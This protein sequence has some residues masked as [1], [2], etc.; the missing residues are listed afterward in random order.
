MAWADATAY[1][2]AVQNPRLAFRDA[3]LHQGELAT[4]RLGLP[5]IYTGSFAAVFQMRR[6]AGPPHLAL[7]CFT[8]Q[9]HGLRHRYQQIDAHLNGRRLP[10]MVRFA[11][12]DEGILVGQQRYPLLKMDWVEGL[13]LDQFL[14]QRLGQAGEKRVLRELS[15]LW[16]RLGELLRE[17]EIGHGDLQHG[18]VMLVPVPGTENLALKLIDYDGMYVPE[19]ADDPP[20]EIGHP[21]YQHPGRTKE[22]GY[23]PE[24]DRFSHLV[25]Y[26]TLQAL[27]AGGRDLWQQFYNGD[28]LLLGPDDFQD[29]RNSEAFRTLWQLDKPDVRALTGHLALA[30]TGPV[31]N[32][33][34]LSELVTDSGVIGLTGQ[35]QSRVGE[36][37]GLSAGLRQGAA[38]TVEPLHEELEPLFDPESEPVLVI[39]RCGE[40]FYAAPPLF[41]KRVPCPGC[42]KPLDIPAADVESYDFPELDELIEIEQGASSAATSPFMPSGTPSVTMRGEEVPAS[43]E[44]IGEWL[45]AFVSAGNRLLV[46]TVGEENTIL[47]ALLRPLAVL[48]CFAMPVLLV[49]GVWQ[50]GLYILT[51]PPAIYDV[52][53]TPGEALLTASGGDVRIEGEGSQRRVVVKAPDGNTRIVLSAR[54]QGYEDRRLELQP[55]AGQREKLMIELVRSPAVYQV[56]LTQPLAE[57]RVEGPG[58]TVSGRGSQRTVTVVNPG[59]VPILLTAML[60][61]HAS[62]R[63]EL[64]PVAGE[65]QEL[66]IE[67]PWL[68]PTMTNSIDMLLVEIPAGEFLMGSSDSDRDASSAEKPKRR[69][70]ITQP[71][72]LGV[73]PV[74]QAQWERVMGSNPSRFK[75]PDHP[76]ERVSWNDCQEFIRRLNDLPGERG[77][78]YRLPTE[79]EWE[80]ACRA[81]STT[82]YSFGD[83]AASLG[84]YAWYVSNSGRKTH[85]VGQKKPNSWGL[86]DMHGN[87]W[88]WCQDWHDSGYYA[89]AASPIN[90]PTGPIAGSNRVIRGGSWGSH[91]RYCRSANRNGHTP[92]RRGYDLGFRLAFSSVDQSGH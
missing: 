4:N 49:L 65:T 66:S 38:A 77:V 30:T 15:R 89:A 54:L 84:D 67:L 68:L 92:S 13:R 42:G 16:L 46:R 62:V 29:P 17:A 40:S 69:V 41:G 74:T 5:L 60:D 11:Y 44:G 20:G 31:E 52:Q 28:R 48:G 86:Y 33:P 36:I 23:G 70:R 59:G 91:A 19:L 53:V 3:E 2:E 24:V 88:E 58:V 21:A 37:L 75:G 27:L 55:V 71:F 26:T 7:K 63:R 18:N 9:V 61:G 79:A 64:K 82:V 32:V 72:F 45:S 83:S 81:G 8:R 6:P 78:V 35:Q 50:A 57:L 25:I 90:D 51:R 56:R 12:Q 85:P 43:P 87:V 1:S 14:E 39:C 76:V 47:L 10:F 22:T 80:Y 73:Y 34:L